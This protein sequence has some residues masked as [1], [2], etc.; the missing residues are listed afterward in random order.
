MS[1]QH[2]EGHFRDGHQDAKILPQ[3]KGEKGKEWKEERKVEAEEGLEVKKNQ[4]SFFLADR[5]G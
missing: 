4:V 3:E 2:S 1:N 5:R